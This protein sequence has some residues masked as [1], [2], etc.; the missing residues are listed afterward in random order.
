MGVFIANASVCLDSRMLTVGRP[1]NAHG[2]QLGK[3]DP[4]HFPSPA[5]GFRWSDIEENAIFAHRGQLAD[6][7]GSI[8]ARVSSVVAFHGGE[9][10]SSLNKPIDHRALFL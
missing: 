9:R 1:G 6:Q 4:H 8:G 5:E 2:H 10:S 7:A 3:E